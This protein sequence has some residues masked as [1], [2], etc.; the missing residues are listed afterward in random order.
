MAD[1]ITQQSVEELL[2]EEIDLFGPMPPAGAVELPLL[3]LVLAVNRL[4]LHGEE[5]SL[6]YWLRRGLRRSFLRTSRGSGARLRRSPVMGA[7]LRH[8]TRFSLNSPAG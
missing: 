1:P 2:K 4:R 7:V 5:P 3:G 8:R 6:W